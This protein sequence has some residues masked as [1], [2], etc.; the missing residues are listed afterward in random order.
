MGTNYRFIATAFGKNGQGAEE[1]FDEQTKS[2][3][4]Q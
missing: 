1:M 3:V 4:G 2:F